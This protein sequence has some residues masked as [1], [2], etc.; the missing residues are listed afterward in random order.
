MFYIKEVCKLEYEFIGK[1]VEII[2]N[3]EFT[4]EETFNCGQCF[5][6]QKINDNTFEGVAF[7]KYLRICEEPNK[8][9][10]INTTRE[11][12]ENIWKNYFDLDLDYNKVKEEL[13]KINDLMETTCNFAPGIRILS[14]DP[15]ETL[16][17]FIISQNNNIPRIRGI[18]SRLCERFGKKLFDGVYAFPDASDLAEL[19]EEDLKPLKSGFRAGYILDAARKITHKEIILDDIKIMDIESAREELQK[20]KGVGPKVADC[21]LLYG[22]HRL[23]AFPMD[24]W[25]KRAMKEMFV[26]ISP[27]DFGEYAG[28]AQQYIFHYSRMNPELVNKKWVYCTK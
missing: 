13:S 6:W 25:M 26:G 4:L 8:L 7:S 18:I 20:I 3:G 14:Q 27:K 9:I 23:E 21:T 16:C 22:F 28:I 2:S 19:S 10:L 1:N 24:V 15:W 11:D 12:F 17:S 5:R